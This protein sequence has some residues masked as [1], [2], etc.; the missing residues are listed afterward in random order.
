MQGKI[1]VNT[2]VGKRSFIQIE[3]SRQAYRVNEQRDINLTR[4]LSH[5]KLGAVRRLSTVKR[6]EAEVRKFLQ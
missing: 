6:Q 2:Q 3:L 1:T 5:G 4:L